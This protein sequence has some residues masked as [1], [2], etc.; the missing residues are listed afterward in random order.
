MRGGDVDLDVLVDQLEQKNYLSDER[1][2]GEYIRYRS[3]RGYGP[4]KIRFELH[5]R[6]VDAEIIQQTMSNSGFDWYGAARCQRVKKFGEA[7]P[8]TIK[9]KIKQSRFL[10]GRGFDGEM[11]RFAMENQ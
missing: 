4:L 3:Q 7:L 2:A 11:V 9:E 5:C 10:V 6:G 1:F 8:Q